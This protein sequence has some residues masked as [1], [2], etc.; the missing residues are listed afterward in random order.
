MQQVAPSRARQIHDT[1]RAAAQRLSQF[2]RMGRV[3]PEFERDSLREI[4]VERYRVIY[5]LRDDVVAVVTVL[6]SA[7]DVETR[8][9]QLRPDL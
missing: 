9:R 8:L 1:L 2:P 3:V 7:T 4:V 5:E 6:H